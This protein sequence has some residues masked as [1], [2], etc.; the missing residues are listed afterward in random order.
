MHPLERPTTAKQPVLP[1]AYVTLNQL[2]A[3]RHKPTHN[4]APGSKVV[5]NRAGQKLSKL[6]GRG[7][8]FSEVRPYQPGDDIRSI[9]W[10]VTA[11]KNKPHTKIFREERERPTLIVVDQT[12][13]MFFGSK[14]RL[15]SV[16]AAE[17]ATRI[18][19][20][21]L[22]AGDR[23]GGIV[24]GNTEQVVHKP[25][26][27]TKSVARFLNS[28]ITLNTTLSNQPP[29]SSGPGDL[30]ATSLTEGLIR[31]RR[32][33]HNNYR[34]FVVSNFSYPVAFWQEHLHQV[35]RHNEVVLVHITDPLDQELPA[36]DHYTVTDGNERLQFYTGETT[37]RN[38]YRA[39]YQ[40]QVLDLKHMSMHDAMT[41][42]SIQTVDTHLDQMS[43]V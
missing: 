23:V 38:R 3:L 6:K 22:A 34:V 33:C 37:L 43:W 1:G 29:P 24:V 28:I 13:H 11:R 32:L 39:R 26:R 36:A 15:K 41:Y 17:V 16:T 35:A 42:M 2:L 4:S 21:N 7:V 5:G 20:Q 12:Q 40:Q 18:A 19:W 31:L 9:D 14:L 25:F 10:R 27:T 30:I 8:D